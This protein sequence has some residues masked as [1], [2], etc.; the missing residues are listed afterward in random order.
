LSLA[1]WAALVGLISPGDAGAQR[2]SLITGMVSDSLTREPVAGVIVSVDD[3]PGDTT[4][5]DGRYRV[6]VPGLGVHRIRLVHPRFRPVL[7]GI[8][9]TVEVPRAGLEKTIDVAWPDLSLLVEAAC[10]PIRADDGSVALLGVVRGVRPPGPLEAVAGTDSLAQESRKRRKDKTRTA[11]VGR[12]V[13][14]RAD[15]GFLFCGLPGRAELWVYLKAGV[16]K[17]PSRRIRL[18]FA[19]YIEMA[20]DPP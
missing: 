19:G 6:A 15:G 12:G 10:G 7:G 11:F 8:S 3:V 14:V 18:P 13:P 2:P 17:G 9:F 20:L 5:P 4:G 16:A 1:V